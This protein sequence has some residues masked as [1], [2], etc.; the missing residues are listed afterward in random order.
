[1]TLEGVCICLTKN[2]QTMETPRFPMNSEKTNLSPRTLTCSNTRWESDLGF[3]L[4]LFS[5]QDPRCHLPRTSQRL[6]VQ[7]RPGVGVLT[8]HGAPSSWPPGGCVTEAGSVLPDIPGILQDR[9]PHLPKLV[10]GFNRPFC[11][12]LG[13]PQRENTNASRQAPCF[14]LLPDPLI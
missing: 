5:S 12:A 11:T 4:E 14:P 6:E 2:P 10:C 9:P 8:L 3:L 7:C 1:M 13:F